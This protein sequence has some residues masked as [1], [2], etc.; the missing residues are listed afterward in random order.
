VAAES[1]PAKIRAT[2]RSSSSAKLPVVDIDG[3]QIHAI[4]ER[5]AIEHILD[6]LDA[7]RG[8]VVVTPNLDHLRRCRSDVHFEALVAEADLVVA[9]GMPLVWASRLQGTRLP[10]RVAGSNMISTLS[11]SA[12]KRGR[13]VFMLGGDEGTAEGAAKVLQG[14][15]PGLKVA[16]T[17][18]PAPGFERNKRVMADLREMLAAS[19]ADIVY[20]AL[21]S[22]K[23]ERLI[24]SIR[25]ELPQAWWLGV[26]VSFSFL[27]GQ[28]KRAPQWMQRHGVEWIH[29]L[30]QEP[31]RLF[32]RYLMVGLPFGIGLLSRSA[33]RGFAGGLWRRTQAG[34]AATPG[35]VR[36]ADTA[37]A[38]NA[39]PLPSPSDEPNAE[40]SIRVTREPASGPLHDSV[41]DFI[42]PTDQPPVDRLSRLRAL[43]LLGGSI[44]PSPLA[45]ATGRSVLDLP[46]D[47]G[48][49][50]LNFW[51]SQAVDMSRVA[52]L[53]RLPVRVLVNHASSEPYTADE[54]YYGTFRV[55]R[56]QSEYRGTGGVLR[57]VAAEYAD[58][59]MILVANAAQVLID[60][61]PVIATA[62]ERK[63]GDV[64]LISHDD[65]TPGGVMLLSCKALRLIPATG[66]VDMKEQMLPHIAAR[67][68]VRVVRRHRPTGIPVRTLEDYIQALRFHHRRRA[69]KPFT[70]DPLAEDFSAAF[71]LIEP[72]STVGAGARV[73]D[74]VVLAG[75]VV[76]PGAALVRSV[77][78]PGADVRKDRTEVDKLVM[79]GVR[80]K[81][82]AGMSAAAAVVAT[83]ALA[84]TTVAATIP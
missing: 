61:L 72:G 81:R 23:Q 48:G 13:S 32:K 62:L 16:G 69:G 54:K 43:V 27:T 52:G 73:H 55:E 44:R 30:C 26:G 71:S 19:G 57:D 59:D 53:G 58:D 18:C 8:G 67:F 36:S 31:R 66:F 29:R 2:R 38:W 63:G 6:E 14:R 4:T 17:Y 75:G 3:V 78:C 47:D 33:S 50:L 20:V 83:A 77:V 68:D 51:L 5:L 45:L 41:S 35:E 10:E 40:P 9:D 82:G 34:S 15:Y 76:E 79:A 22:P 11:G 60:P 65:G 12:A 25:S 84:T 56:D 46:L 49:S 37:L 24:A 80:R 7:G 42:V 64:C 28:V 21:G 1:Q 74:S 39:G 70:T